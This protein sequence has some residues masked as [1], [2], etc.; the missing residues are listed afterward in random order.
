LVVDIGGIT[1]AYWSSQ[2]HRDP[3]STSVAGQ[4]SDGAG[5]SRIRFASMR[6][7]ITPLA[8]TSNHPVIAAAGGHDVNVGMDFDPRGNL[9]TSRPNAVENAV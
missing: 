9:C 5:H 3:R 2:R 6:T 8:W 7:D 4:E 1:Y